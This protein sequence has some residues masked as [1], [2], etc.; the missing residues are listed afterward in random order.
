MG[1]SIPRAS[2]GKSAQQALGSRHELSRQDGDIVGEASP[3][4]CRSDTD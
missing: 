1:A 4:H 3:G 2:R